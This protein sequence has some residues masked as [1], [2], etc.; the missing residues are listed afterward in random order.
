MTF[1]INN[2]DFSGLI[3]VDGY[4]VTPRKVTGPAAGTLLNGEQVADQVAV[5]RDL[6]V[7]VEAGDTATVSSLASLCMEEYVNLIFGDPLSGQ[8]YTGVYMPQANGIPMAIDM[9]HK[10]KTYWYSFSISFKEK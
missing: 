8:N 4:T 7:Q 9:D 1:I 6:T 10:G 2:T 3:K 5:K